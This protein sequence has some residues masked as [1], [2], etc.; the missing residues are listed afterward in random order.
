MDD[1][2]VNPPANAS[3]PVAPAA[4]TAPVDAGTTPPTPPISPIPPTPSE[5]PPGSGGEPIPPRVQQHLDNVPPANEPLKPHHAKKYFLLLISIVLVVLIILGLIWFF[6]LSPKYMAKEVAKIP[7]YPTVAVS[8][9]P[10]PDPTADWETYTDEKLGYSIRYPSGFEVS[11]EGDNSI[12]VEK[13]SSLPG[14]GPDNFVY[15]SVLPVKDITKG[16]AYNFGTY[17]FDLLDKLEVGESTVPVGT[18]DPKAIEGNNYTR[19]EDLTI[20]GKM[21]K[22]FENSRPYEFPEGTVEHRTYILNGN[23]MYLVGAY[24]SESGDVTKLLFNQ[25]L[26]TFT[27]SDAAS[28]ISAEG[29]PSATLTP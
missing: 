19:I 11:P 23:N 25:I 27:F 26:T 21:S 17:R 20:L 5:T 28:S 2:K 14:R 1:Q 8:P 10:T 22:L 6:F 24:F 29:T 12:T 16:G 7:V 13:K 18:D 9:T 3:A 15:I 4:P